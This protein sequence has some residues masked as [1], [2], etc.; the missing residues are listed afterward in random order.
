MKWRVLEKRK[1]RGRKSEKAG[2][3]DNRRKIAG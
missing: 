1:K 3:M 2:E